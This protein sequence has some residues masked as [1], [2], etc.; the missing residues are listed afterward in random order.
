MLKGTAMVKKLKT[1]RGRA[2]GGLRKE[3]Y[4]SL[5]IYSCMS[6][7]LYN[8][9][10]TYMVLRTRRKKWRTLLSTKKKRDGDGEVT[11]ERSALEP[12]TSPTPSSAAAPE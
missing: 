4:M 10:G 12:L 1:L 9:F 2:T 11:S 3:A 5:G 8:S 6:W 7:A